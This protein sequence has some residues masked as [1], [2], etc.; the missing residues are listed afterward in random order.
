MLNVEEAKILLLG[1]V[2]P[3]FYHYS[4]VSL[5]DDV[6]FTMITMEWIPPKSTS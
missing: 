4:T 3:L 2:V 6:N 1:L 5:I